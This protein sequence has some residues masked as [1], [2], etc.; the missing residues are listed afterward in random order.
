MRR[1]GIALLITS[2]LLIFS[3]IN[4]VPTSQKYD[5]ESL[6][7]IISNDDGHG[8]LI[9]AQRSALDSRNPPTQNLIGY[10]SLDDT[11]GPITDS[12][13]YQHSATTHG[14]PTYNATGRFG[15]AVDFDGTDDYFDTG[16]SIVEMINNS[17]EFTLSAWV[18]TTS[19]GSLQI[20]NAGIGNSWL[21]T[22]IILSIEDGNARV[23]VPATDLNYPVIL[24]NF[25]INDGQWH[26]ITGTFFSSGNQSVLKLYIDGSLDATI[27]DFTW[28][29]RG[30][31]HENQYNGDFYIG[32][33][34]KDTPSEHFYSGVLDE[35]RIYDRALTTAEV[36]AFYTDYTDSDGD[37]VVDSLDQCEGHDDSVDGD[38]DGIPDGCDDLQDSD[39]DGIA[40]SSD[41]CEGHDDSVDVDGDGIPDGCDDLQD[42][43][44]DGVSDDIDAFPFDASESIDSDGDGVGNN[45]D[46]CPTSPSGEILSSIG[47]C[48][49]IEVYMPTLHLDDRECYLPINRHWDDF[50]VSN[51]FEN[52]RDSRVDDD[53]SSYSSSSSPTPTVYY[54]V[55]EESNHYVFEYW[56]YYADSRFEAYPQITSWTIH[57]HDFEWAFVWV[58]KSDMEPYYFA[59]SQHKWVNEHF[60]SSTDELWANVEWGGHG[61]AHH[62]ESYAPWYARGDGLV[63]ESGDFEFIQMNPTAADIGMGEFLRGDY[64]D[65]GIQCKAPWLQPQFSDPD[66]IVDDPP[67]GISFHNDML[68]G[69][70]IGRLFSPA[71]LYVQDNEGRIT[72][73]FDGEIREEIPLSWYDAE[74]EMVIIFGNGSDYEFF[75][76]G[77]ANATYGLS[78]SSGNASNVTF[79]NA[80]DIPTNVGEMHHY[81]VN[82]STLNVNDTAVNITVDFENDGIVDHEFWSDATLN[83]SEFTTATTPEPEPEPEPPIIEGNLTCPDGF[84]LSLEEECVTTDSTSVVNVESGSISL[85][86]VLAM[87]I[88]AILAGVICVMF[89]IRRQKGLEP[90]VDDVQKQILGGEDTSQKPTTSQSFG[91]IPFTPPPEAAGNISEDGYE[92]LESPIGSGVWYWRR[93][94]DQDWNQWGDND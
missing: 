91:T 92:W 21:G 93:S 75:V 17:G 55:K 77:K 50:D 34:N 35:I 81:S 53:C 58:D 45:A 82:W 39:G 23:A 11:S 44:G 40:D 62:W 60:I 29:T 94:S 73:L 8:Q 72:G 38:G 41:Q 74:R 57:E 28:D 64:C 7:D 88:L 14:A 10:W 79:F 49:L 59:L 6:E 16:S 85:T 2:I 70:T 83:Q 47:G 80:T 43:D 51:N 54:E 25:D 32:A 87:S 5:L 66:L 9:D 65:F 33:E 46:P 89:I 31:N 24:S 26:L 52:Y 56:F 90:K 63:L 42:S 30:L 19:N 13:G 3:M 22:L 76:D 69:M 27:S 1:V 36:S 48:T 84:E 4:L 71:E 78:L 68:A 20:I 86:S 18:N 15:N 12:S 61:M 37:G 67:N